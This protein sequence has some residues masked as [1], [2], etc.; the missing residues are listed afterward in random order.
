VAALS[1]LFAVV[2]ACCTA[3]AWLLP[4]VRGDEER[5][6]VLLVAAVTAWLL[7]EGV[8]FVGGVIAGHSS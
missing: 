6:T 2:A 1:A 8:L 7:A 3:G 4:G 5:C